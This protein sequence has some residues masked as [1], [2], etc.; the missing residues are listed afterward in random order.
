M[1]TL[2]SMI[3]RYCACFL[4][5]RIFPY[6]VVQG[7]GTVIVGDLLGKGNINLKEV[8]SKFE[9]A[10]LKDHVASWIGNGKNL[11]ISKEQVEKAL[12]SG[13]L[14]EIANKFGIQVEQVSTQLAW[15]LPA[16]VDRLTLDGELPKT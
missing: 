10:G 8:L 9:S 16:Q 5:R 1:K 2:L 13:Q 11:P 3:W 4:R 12:G 7:N 15:H 14:K 6:S